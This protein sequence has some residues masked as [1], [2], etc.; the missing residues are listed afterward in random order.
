MAAAHMRFA[1]PNGD[2]LSDEEIFR[3]ESWSRNTDQEVFD[4]GTAP[5]T[6]QPLDRL[7][8]R[9]PDRYLDADAIEEEA[10]FESAM[11]DRPLS[12]QVPLRGRRSGNE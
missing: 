4:Y 11:D 12:H 10:I 5:G 9:D 6:D 2:I 8:Q 3:L 1:R 7:P